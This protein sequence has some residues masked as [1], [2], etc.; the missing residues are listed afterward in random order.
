MS[1]LIA[2]NPF[3]SSLGPSVLVLNPPLSSFS[4]LSVFS[5]LRSLSGRSNHSV[6]SQFPADVATHYF[7][8]AEAP[9][10]LAWLKWSC[11]E[12]IDDW[13]ITP[14]SNQS[15]GIAD[16]LSDGAPMHLAQSEVM[17][18][19]AMYFWVS[20]VRAHE[21]A[22][23]SG[24]D[25]LAAER[26]NRWYR[27]VVWAQT[28]TARKRVQQGKLGCCYLGALPD[29]CLA[30]QRIGLGMI[31]CCTMRSCDHKGNVAR[32]KQE[33]RDTDKAVRK[34]KLEYNL[35]GSDRRR[36]EELKRTYVAGLAFGP[37][38]VHGPESYTEYFA[39]VDD[40]VITADISKLRK[41]MCVYRMTDASYH[42]SAVMADAGPSDSLSAQSS[43]QNLQ[44][45]PEPEPKAFTTITSGSSSHRASNGKLGNRRTA[46]FQNPIRDVGMFQ[47]KSTST[48]KRLQPIKFADTTKLRRYSHECMM[49][50]ADIAQMIIF[51]SQA[52]RLK[53]ANRSNVLMFALALLHAC[54]PIWHALLLPVP[55]GGGCN[56][57]GWMQN[58]HIKRSW[59]DV[60]SA[61]NPHVNHIS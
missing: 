5:V 36:L 16:P 59:S 56:G 13:I 4:V 25:T 33:L 49:Q 21:I 53:H 58:S 37:P 28:S 45:E 17:I 43:H 51:L 47:Q 11:F 2:T 1:L 60:P 14:P 55:L 29:I 40:A 22:S 41:D 32:F 44:P 31:L 57:Y 26:E 12:W 9:T 10:L 42:A 34:T 19:V 27:K 30:L 39:T 3:V 15:S 48:D 61:L 20:I 35:M 38:L 18:P 6:T 54:I 46:F 24:S 50:V 52:R 8:S 23:M 7:G